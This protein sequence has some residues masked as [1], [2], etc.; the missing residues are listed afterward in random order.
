MGLEYDI[1][2]TVTVSAGAQRT[3]YGIK[4]D[5][6]S[7]TS[8]ACDSYSVGFGAAFNVIKGLRVNLGY[9]CSIYKDYNRNTNYG[10]KTDPTQAL[11]ALETYSRTNHVLG[12]GIDYKF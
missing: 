2:K 3:D 12:V 10:S 7:N 11:P 4:D 8:F 6:Q 5:F 1:N 9:F